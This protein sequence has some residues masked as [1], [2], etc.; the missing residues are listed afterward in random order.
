MSTDAME[1]LSRLAARMIAGTAM[2]EPA[3]VP[4]FFKPTPQT[5][6]STCSPVPTPPKGLEKL[7]FSTEQVKL[8]PQL[9]PVL[10]VPNDSSGTGG[11]GATS[12]PVPTGGRK[13]Y[14]IPIA[15]RIGT[16]RTG[17][18]GENSRGLER[19]VT[20]NAEEG[21]TTNDTPPDLTWTSPSAHTVFIA[22]Q[23]RP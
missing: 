4:P 16:G 14:D 12:L 15:C 21:I 10:P 8:S 1:R 9:Q 2:P 22:D 6:C 19:D 13:K 11:T 20:N 23:T 3:S 17:E 7:D 5:T 18:T